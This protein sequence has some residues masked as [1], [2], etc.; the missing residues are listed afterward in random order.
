[1]THPLRGIYNTDKFTFILI[2][3]CDFSVKVFYAHF[4]KGLKMILNVEKPIVTRKEDF[5]IRRSFAEAMANAI[6]NLDQPS[7][8]LTIGLYGKWG[9]GKTSII[10]MSIEKLKEESEDTLIY[11]FEPWIYSDTQQ[12][13]SHFFKGFSK[14]INRHDNAD[15]AGRN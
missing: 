8:S 1:M 10:N 3:Y 11:N 15:I 4:Y 6:I 12:L 9:S 13:I 7:E 14:V 2:K 5:L